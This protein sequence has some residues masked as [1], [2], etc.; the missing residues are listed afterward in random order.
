MGRF[1]DGRAE[2]GQRILVSLAQELER[3]FS[4]GFSYSALT[5]MARFA[6]QFPE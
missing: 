1:R 6:E 5:R 3:E 2:Y 4:K